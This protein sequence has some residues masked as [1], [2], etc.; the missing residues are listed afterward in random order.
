MNA[1][2][3]AGL[4]L[5]PLISGFILIPDAAAAYVD[6]QNCH[7]DPGPGSD[8]K[9]Y[10]DYFIEPKRQHPVGIDY[11]QL[12]N[13]DYRQPT[14]QAANVTFFDTNGNGIADLDEIQLFGT[15]KK[16]ECSSCHM[17]HGDVLPPP[18]HVSMYLRVTNVG[19]ALC[20]TCHSL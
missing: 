9:S 3:L 12:P 2:K 10:I 6:C 7:F 13:T 8:A 18:T 1:A 15:S 5:A 16:V 20:A 11:P 14:V 19:D 4:C 17:G